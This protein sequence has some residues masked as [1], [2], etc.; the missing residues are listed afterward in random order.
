MFDELTALCG[1]VEGDESVRVV[2]LT[3]AGR[4]FCA[5]LDLQAAALWRRRWR[6]SSSA[7]RRN[8]V[9]LTGGDMGGSWLLPRIVGLGIA[10]ELPL[11]GRLVDAEEAGRIGLVNR[12]VEPDDLL[13]AA[14]K[15]AREIILNSPLRFA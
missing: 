12:V 11:T 9:G 3:G 2:I 1:D 15:M 6:R 8:G 4:G 5:G 7:A 10:N 14:L 13:P